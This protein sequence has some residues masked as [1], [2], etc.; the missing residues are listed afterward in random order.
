MPWVGYDSDAKK[1]AP[2]SWLTAAVYNW[3]PYYLS[4]VKAAMAGSWKTGFYYGDLKDGFV[5]LAPYGS[6]RQ[7]EDEEPDRQQ[8][9]GLGERLVLGLQRTAQGSV[10][11]GRRARGQEADRAAPV[12]DEL[13]RAGRDRD[14]QVL[15]A[16]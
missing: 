1:F 5:K 4:R 7:R 16:S 6:R 11:Q 10:R 9:E 8:E 3:G 14:G 13:A 15:I 12:R 2:K